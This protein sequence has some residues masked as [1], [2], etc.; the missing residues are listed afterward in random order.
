ML[1]LQDGLRRDSS[2]EKLQKRCHNLVL[3][4]KG[5][6]AELEESHKRAL[7]EVAR[8]KE[9]VVLLTAEIQKAQTFNAAL[10]ERVSTER[11]NA[12][13]LSTQLLAA[14]ADVTTAQKAEAKLKSASTAAAAAANSSKVKSKSAAAKKKAAK[15]VTVAAAVAPASA[16]VANDENMPPPTISLQEAAAKRKGGLKGSCLRD[17]L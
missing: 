5:S 3:T 12:A 8:R 10:K 11:R 2:I 4:Q 15:A 16:P 6:R 7:Q 13:L 1:T 14:L 17:G 9:Q